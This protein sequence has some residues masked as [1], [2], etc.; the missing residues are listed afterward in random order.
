MWRGRG[1]SACRANQFPFQLA[2]L[3][4]LLLKSGEIGLQRKSDF[5]SSFKSTGFAPIEAKSIS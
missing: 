3:R 2:L 1:A 4:S 5:A